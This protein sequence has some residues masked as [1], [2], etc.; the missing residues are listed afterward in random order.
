MK[1][2]EKETY[3][4]GKPFINVKI[5]DKKR[6]SRDIRASLIRNNNHPSH[7]EIG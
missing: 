5:S 7:R 3:Y 1:K 2:S 4:Y 6:E